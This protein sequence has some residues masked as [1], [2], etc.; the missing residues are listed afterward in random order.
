MKEVLILKVVCSFGV[1]V[2]GI[3]AVITHPI[4]AAFIV[5]LSFIVLIAIH[6]TDNGTYRIYKE[7][8]K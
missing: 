3:W 8:S 2:V 6:A 4:V 7:N 1:F 5:P